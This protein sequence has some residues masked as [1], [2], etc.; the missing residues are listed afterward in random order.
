MMNKLSQLRRE[1][2]SPGPVFP[3]SLR[4]FYQH[5][6]LNSCA[7]LLVVITMR[8]NSL[9]LEGDYSVLDG[10]LYQIGIGLELQ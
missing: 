9:N 3:V 5:A 2:L 8:G 10:V 1:R 7:C 6:A 4:N